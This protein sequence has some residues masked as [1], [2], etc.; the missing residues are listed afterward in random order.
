MLDLLSN[1]CGLASSA[2]F[3]LKNV[4]AELLEGKRPSFNLKLEARR[5]Q[6]SGLRGATR[7]RS[8]RRLRDVPACLRPG[9]LS[10]AGFPSRFRSSSTWR[11]WGGKYIPKFVDYDGYCRECQKEHY[12]I[13]DPKSRIGL[14]HSV[15]D[16]GFRTRI[17]CGDAGGCLLSRVFHMPSDIR[18]M[19]SLAARTPAGPTGQR[20]HSLLP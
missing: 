5:L 7:C 11:R 2:A 16:L 3:L 19:H 15:G 10:F 8:R 13:D 4:R 18:R 12:N 17:R 6:P 20:K 1:S 9:R 14:L